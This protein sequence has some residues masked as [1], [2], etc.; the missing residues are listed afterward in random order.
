MGRHPTGR[1]LVLAPGTGEGSCDADRA[2]AARDGNH[3]RE[4]YVANRHPAA[5]GQSIMISAGDLTAELQDLGKAIGLFKYDGSLDVSWFGE[6]LTRLESILTD[7]DQRTALLDLIDAFFPPPTNIPDLAPSEKWH[8]ILGTQPLGNLYF[9]QVPGDGGIV[10]GLAG[11]I[12]GSGSTPRA[13]LRVSVP[14]FETTSS[15]SIE[16]GT[17][18]HPISLTLTVQLKDL[19]SSPQLTLNAVRVAAIVTVTPPSESLQITLEG[20]SIDGAPPQDVPLDAANLT[21][22]AP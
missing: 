16:F 9:T 17:P 11:E 2:S 19:I 12:H 14:I 5:G 21:A 7:S 22:E 10:F 4:A 1:S 20:L 6:P 8:P 3:R 15:V 13:S 18:K